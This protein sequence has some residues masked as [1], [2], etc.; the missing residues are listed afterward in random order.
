MLLCFDLCFVIELL[1]PP[2]WSSYSVPRLWLHTVVSSKY[3]D[4]GISAVIGVNVVTM[5]IE[6]YNMPRVISFSFAY[7]RCVNNCVQ[8]Y[9]WI[10]SPMRHP[11]SS[12]FVINIII[13]RDIFNGACMG[14][15][16]RSTSVF[17][18]SNKEAEYEQLNRNVVR[19]AC[20][21]VAK[22]GR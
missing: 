17:S 6:H 19:L 3:F 20:A 7:I 16:D 5:A 11:F 18:G 10:F 22:C 12:T 14:I 9:C 4:L 15:I 8:Y 2:Y 1:K 21:Q 13:I